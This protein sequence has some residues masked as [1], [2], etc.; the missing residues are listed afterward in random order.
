MPFIA[1]RVR[2]VIIIFYTGLQWCVLILAVQQPPVGEYN[3]LQ[4]LLDEIIIVPLNMNPV[5]LDALHNR[6]GRA[7]RFNI[8]SPGIAH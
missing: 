7:I 2:P 1:E 3:K 6:V 5:I 8:L 4:I